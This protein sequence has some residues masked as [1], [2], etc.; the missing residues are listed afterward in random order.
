MKN[1][2][3]KRKSLLFLF[4]TLLSGMSTYGQLDLPMA[5]QKASVT[6]RVGITDVTITYSRPAVK[7]REV[8]GKLV[9]Y[10]MVNLGFGTAKESPWRAGANENTTIHF[11]HDVSIQGKELKAGTYG[12]HMILHENQKVDVI[13]SENSTAWGSYFYDPAD[14]A[15]RIT[16]D[17]KSGPHTEFLTFEF[18]DFDKNSTTAALRWAEK[19][20]PFR[21]QV[22]A[23]EIV[24]TQIR[25]DLQ[26]QK[27]FLDYNWNQAANWSMSNGGDMEEALAWSEAAINDPY[28]GSRNYNNMQTKARILEEMGK[29]DESYKVMQEAMEMGTVFQVHAYG[30]Q[31]IAQGEKERALEVFKKNA[32]MHKNTWPVNYGLARGYS[33]MGDYKKALNYLEKAYEL[34]PEQANKDRVK[35]NMEKLKKG[36]DIN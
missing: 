22:D 34:A 33:A 2:I 13:F 6:Q 32:E 7:G 24:L 29:T 35:S 26:G 25:K 12:L 16:V 30:R 28:V 20:I 21:I 18:P 15:L 5:S 11:T 31:L 14:D 23:T 8:W 10:G 9:P 3:S 1:K 17:S 27:G 36:E 4:L 19:V